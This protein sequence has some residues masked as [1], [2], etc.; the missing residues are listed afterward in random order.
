VVTSLSP[1]DH[2]AFAAEGDTHEK[3]RVGGKTIGVAVNGAKVNPK[4]TPA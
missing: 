3:M 2:D 4:L 1:R